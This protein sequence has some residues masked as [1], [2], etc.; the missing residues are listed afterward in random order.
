MA[1]V[2]VKGS[3]Q[4][5]Q[6]TRLPADPAGRRR[7]VPQCGQW[8]RPVMLH[9]RLGT[10]EYVRGLSPTIGDVN[11]TIGPTW[12]EGI[13]ELDRARPLVYAGRPELVNKIVA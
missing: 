10:H 5:P 2:Q 1:A 7:A 13:D 9:A 4:R 11:F 12:D 6:A 8:V 3:L